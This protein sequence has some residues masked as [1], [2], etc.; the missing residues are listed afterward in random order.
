MQRRQILARS[1]A[2]ASLLTP[3]AP[4]A[5]AQATAARAAAPAAKA[6]K[7]AGT[8]RIVIPANPGGG[9]DQTGRALGAINTSHG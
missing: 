6:A 3:L 8:L 7:V 2:L 4:A 1:A 9:W 5:L